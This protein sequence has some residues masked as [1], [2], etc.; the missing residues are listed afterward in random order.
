M[1]RCVND[2]G[3]GDSFRLDPIQG[4][5]E[6][7]ERASM[8]G[9]NKLGLLLA[10]LDLAP[11]RIEDNRPIAREELTERYLDIHWEHARPLRIQQ[12]KGAGR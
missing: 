7:M 9:T 4:I 5:L 11:E 1:I 2:V 10:L 6:I 3:H 12:V 8:T